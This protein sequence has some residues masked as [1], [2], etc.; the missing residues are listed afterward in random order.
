MLITFFCLCLTNQSFSQTQDV[1]FSSGW[2]IIPGVR[3]EYFNRKVTWGDQE[4]L[5]DMQAIIFALN[6]E[7][8]IDEGFSVSAF[9]GYA[10]SSYEMLTF[11]QLPFSIELDKEKMGGYILGAEINKSLYDHNDLEFGLMGQFLYH[12]GKEKT[13][14]LPGLNVPGD[15]SGKP[16]WMR[17]YGGAY[18]K[19][20]G[21][22]S[23]SPYF[24]VCY[25]NLWGQWKMDQIIQDLDGTE[26][27]EVQSKSLVDIILGSILSLNESFSL[28]G[29]AHVLPHSNGID[30]GIVAI[31][32]FSF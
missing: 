2:R 11:R 10:L 24:A 17:A 15:V 7:I 6:L 19:F 25:N 14:N 20:T 31:A 12:S 29:E 3:F 32:A 21:I 28:K 8:E 26:E 30:L 16:E 13:W 23:F 5:S 18:I 1:S 4:D 27:K 9:A 22:E